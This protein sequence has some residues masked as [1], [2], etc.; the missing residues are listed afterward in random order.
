RKEGIVYLENF[1]DG[2][3][4]LKLIADYDRA[5]ER[6]TEPASRPTDLP[7]AGELAKLGAG[8]HTKSKVKALLSSYGVKVARETLAASPDGAA[9]AASNFDFPVVLKVVSPDIVHK[10]DVG[11][12]RVGL[13]SAEEIRVA[14]EA[15]TERIGR[16]VPQ[17]RLEGFS[18]QEMI[19]GEAEIF[20]GVRRDPQ[21]GPIV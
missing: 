20:I 16:E 6:V 15:M 12:V 4:A 18:V 9:D 11:G 17:A 13:G 5:L 21:F 14:A 7:A 3:R 2:L 8:Y 1:E 19:S 10:S